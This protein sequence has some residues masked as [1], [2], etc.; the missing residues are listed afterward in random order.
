MQRITKVKE[1]DQVKKRQDRLNALARRLLRNIKNHAE[2]CGY[3]LS[4]E[5]IL[6]AGNRLAG[7]KCKGF[8]KISEAAEFAYTYPKT[9]M[10]FLELTAIKVDEGLFE[11]IMRDYSFHAHLGKTKINERDIADVMYGDTMVISKS[12]KILSAISRII[13]EEIGIWLKK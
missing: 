6:K 1:S 8:T 9:I 3:E 12:N 7:D 5:E 4:D 2:D 10:E 11:Y 13:V